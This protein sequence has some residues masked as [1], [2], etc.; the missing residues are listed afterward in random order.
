MAKTTKSIAPQSILLLALLVAAGARADC[1]DTCQTAFTYVDSINPCCHQYEIAVQL[2]HEKIVHVLPMVGW[3]VQHGLR[4]A[5][6]TVR[7]RCCSARWRILNKV[8]RAA[9]CY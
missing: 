2:M 7:F 9:W 5:S 1:T 3:T 8:R 4:F 6:A